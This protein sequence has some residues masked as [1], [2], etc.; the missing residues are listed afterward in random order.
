MS[1][2]KINICIVLY[3]YRLN[4]VGAAISAKQAIYA[5]VGGAHATISTNQSLCQVVGA[6]VGDV[7]VTIRAYQSQN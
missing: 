2:E 7:L 6:V 4:G 5:A 1:Q 3:L